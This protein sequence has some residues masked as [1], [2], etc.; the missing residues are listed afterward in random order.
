M[1]DPGESFAPAPGAHAEPPR[2][3]APEPAIEKEV[4]PP[5]PAAR[6]RISAE[7]RETPIEEPPLLEPEPA[8][9]GA[10]A[11]EPLSS[12]DSELFIEGEGEFP[13]DDESSMLSHIPVD[14][15]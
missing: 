6:P 2:K 3:R 15:R 12:L 8:L 7:R 1:D 11:F 9:E 10:M 5:R 4:P 13:G 14:E